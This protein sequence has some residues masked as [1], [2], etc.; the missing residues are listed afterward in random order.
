MKNVSVAIPLALLLAALILNACV[1]AVMVGGA[2]AGA[3]TAS[4]RRTLSQQIDDKK[5][6]SMVERRIE[7]NFG[8]TIHVNAN[9]FNGALLL[10]GETP[11]AELRTAFQKLIPTFPSTKRIIDETRQVPVSPAQWRLNDAAMTTKVK[12]RL[13]NTEAFH[14]AHIKV[15]SEAN[16]IFLMGR[17]TQTEANAAIDI[18]RT[19]SGVNR[20]INV[21]EITTEEALQ[22]EAEAT[23]KK[24]DEKSPPADATKK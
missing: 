13:A 9:A 21:F 19:T 11:T 17:V 12:S 4:D 1:P 14:I 7:E 23:E 10:T 24:S 6:E 18:A 2:V 16:D 22:R 3:Y 8:E 20:V 15:I 5:L